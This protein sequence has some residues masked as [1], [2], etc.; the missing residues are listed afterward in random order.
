[1]ANL[2]FAKVM[3][4]NKN[5]KSKTKQKTFSLF[6]LLL[7]NSFEVQKTW[8]QLILKAKL[9]NKGKKCLWITFLF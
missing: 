9:V 7:G 4:G 5:A 6:S 2:S 3:A 1:L 8:L